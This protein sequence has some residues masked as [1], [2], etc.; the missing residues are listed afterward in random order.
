MKVNNEVFITQ[1]LAIF[2][3]YQFHNQVRQ[4]IGHKQVHH[5]VVLQISIKPNVQLKNSRLI[6]TIQLTLLKKNLRKYNLCNKIGL[7]VNLVILTMFLPIVMSSNVLKLYGLNTKI[8]NYNKKDVM[9][10]QKPPWTNGLKQ[11][12]EW[13]L[14]FKEK[15]SIKTLVLISQR[16][17]VL[18]GQTGSLKIS[19][20]CT[21]L[22]KK[23]PQLM[24]VR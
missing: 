17:V 5:L 16:L 23:I 15:K 19:I 24:T 13:K 21:T 22:V 7:K 2:M 9:R 8:E 20:L 14:R 18:F 4:I 12:E 6:R 10:R 11:G 1:T 3:T